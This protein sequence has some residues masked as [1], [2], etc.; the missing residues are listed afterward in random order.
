M[1]EDSIEHSR[2]MSG[3]RLLSIVP[4]ILNNEVSLPDNVRQLMVLKT[5]V[6]YDN[7]AG[8]DLEI[9]PIEALRICPPGGHGGAWNSR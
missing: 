1:K 7:Q 2:M 8:G 4:G 3:A 9:R 5:G 6:N